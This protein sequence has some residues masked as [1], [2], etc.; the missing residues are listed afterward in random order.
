MSTMSATPNSTLI[1][2]DNDSLYTPSAGPSSLSSATGTLHHKSSKESIQSHQTSLSN[3]S[4]HDAPSAVYKDRGGLSVSDFNYS[5]TVQKSIFSLR[6]DSDSRSQSTV[7][8]TPGVEPDRRSRGVH[9]D[10]DESLAHRHPGIPCYHC[11]Q[12]IVGA[13]FRCVDCTT[14]DI[15]LCWNCEIAGFPGDLDAP[16][17]RHN[18]SHAMLKIPMSLNMQEIQRVTRRADYL[19]HAGGRADGR[20]VSPFP[21]PQRVPDGFVDLMPVISSNPYPT[22]SWEERP[23]S[24]SKGVQVWSTRPEKSY[25]VQPIECLELTG[26]PSRPGMWPSWSHLVRGGECWQGGSRG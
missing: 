13:R 19:R 16:D 3:F 23:A 11:Q 18:S 14:I 21:P 12:D 4:T 9:D 20:I 15:D 10:V 8:V 26:P 2:Q 24:P 22:T 17:G 6:N 7:C 5:D 25:V 1:K